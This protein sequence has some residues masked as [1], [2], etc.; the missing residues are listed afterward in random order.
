M[1]GLVP[2][3]RIFILSG[4]TAV[5]KGTVERRLRSRY[6]QLETSIS[7]TTREP[8]PGEV[9]GVDYY[10]VSDQGFDRLIETDALLE[11]A[12]VHGK[13]RYGTPRK[14]V[15]EHAKSGYP[16]LLEVD[17]EGARQLRK[18]LPQAT[19][20]FLEP[21]SWEELE[22]RLVGRGTEEPAQRQRRLE[23]AKTEMAAK[24]EFSVVVT[25]DNLDSTVERLADIMGL[26]YP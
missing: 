6:P 18:T 20:I 14:W 15:E 11:W 10:F 13:D 22:R 23:T 2:D 8:R 3:T 5:G 7:V 12:A 9:D 25:N 19:S 26:D 24:A 16:V 4:P 21:P 1:I 17:L